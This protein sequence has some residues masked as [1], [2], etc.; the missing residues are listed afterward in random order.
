MSISYAFEQFRCCLVV[1]DR[2]FTSY[3]V[4]SSEGGPSGCDDHDDER[5]KSP[6]WRVRLCVLGSVRV[7]VERHVVVGWL[8]GWLMMILSAVG[9]FRIALRIRQHDHMRVRGKRIASLR[10]YSSSPL[11]ERCGVLD[12]GKWICLANFKVI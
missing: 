5:R 7:V 1:Y 3:G 12:G 8:V 11:Q 9:V 4:G 6:S 10:D 2:I